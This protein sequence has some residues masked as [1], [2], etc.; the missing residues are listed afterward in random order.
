MP[1]DAALVVRANRDSPENG[2]AAGPMAYGDL[3]T[4][5][6]LNSLR[7][8]G[9]ARRDLR[10]NDAVG[11]KFESAV[12][13]EDPSLLV[14][15]G[16][17][18]PDTWVG[19]YVE[20]E[21]GYST[22]MTTHN[23]GLMGGRVVYLLSCLTGR[24]LGPAMVRLGAIAYTGYSD[25][26]I[27]TV[28]SPE[29]PATDR[30]AAPFGNASTV[31]PKAL[32][33]GKTVREAKEKALRVFEAEMERWEKSEDPYAR[34]VVKWLLWDRDAFTVLG[35]EGARGLEPRIALGL[36]LGAIAIGVVAFML[37]RRRGK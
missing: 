35:D 7:W 36:L 28:E 22:L 37:I 29:S 32:V 12:R 5:W 9:G 33:E 6:V 16:H 15:C 27:W 20:K 31:F 24:E 17:G 10:G 26:F 19:Q 8:R 4:G 34:E 23:A 11:V 30:L 14:G 13:T 21:R 1:R 3:W 25:E 18:N 2:G